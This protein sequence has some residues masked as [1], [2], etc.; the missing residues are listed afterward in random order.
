MNCSVHLL[1]MAWVFCSLSQEPQLPPLGWKPIRKFTEPRKET[2]YFKPPS[3]TSHMKNT[4]GVT[5][6]TV[7][8]WGSLPLIP[9]FPFIRV[10]LQFEV[11]GLDLFCNLFYSPSGGVEHS[12]SWVVV[13]QL[14]TQILHVPNP[15]LTQIQRFSFPKERLEIQK[16]ETWL[17]RGSS[18]VTIA[19][20]TDFMSFSQ[21]RFNL[22]WVSSKYETHSVLF[23]HSLAG[24]GAR[25][26]L[27]FSVQLSPAVLKDHSNFTLLNLHLQMKQVRLHL[28]LDVLQRRQVWKWEYTA[29]RRHGR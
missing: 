11:R 23:D 16:K 10:L 20:L 6:M 15:L 21:S 9:L 7:R 29:D 26:G 2:S 25:Q 5:A 12:I 24:A 28:A 14:M 1:L 4:L 18:T 27:Y 22:F 8:F 17:L 13:R 3:L 19:T